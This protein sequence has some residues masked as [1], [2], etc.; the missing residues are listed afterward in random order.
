[1]N[2]KKLLSFFIVLIIF[3]FLTKNVIDNWEQLRIATSN[4]SPLNL[5]LIFL[6]SVLLHT[7]DTTSWHMITKSLKFKITFSQNLRIWILPNV[8]RYVPGVVWQYLGRMYLLSKQGV[9]KK[10]GMLAVLLNALFT[11]STGALVMLLTY[12]MGHAWILILI[13][14]VILIAPIVFSNQKLLNFVLG[15]LYKVTKKK[16]EHKNVKFKFRW[17]LLSSLTT[18]SQFIFAGVMLFCIVG[19][20]TEISWQLI[21]FF[22][23]IY[24]G[25][26]IL[27]YISFFAPGGLGIQEISM[28]GLLSL[29][30]PMPVA[31]LSAILFRFFLVIA[32]ISVIIFVI[33]RSGNFL[34]RLPQVARKDR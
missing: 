4:L 12:S 14:G 17:L 16:F 3:S 8:S 32:E 27:G 26:W 5:I 2:V 19:S 6:I 29:F 28:A 1:M 20:L 11:F 13:I 34:S 21:P 23:G 22:A 24:A 7:L 9:D 25:A 10:H 30:V 33:L 31:S 15:V 18:F